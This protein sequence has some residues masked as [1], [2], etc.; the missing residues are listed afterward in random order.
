M[1]IKVKVKAGMNR[2]IFEEK[3]PDSFYVSVRE[4]AHQNLANDR[5]K[6]LIERHFGVVEGKVRLV[7]GQRS[8]SKIFTVDIDLV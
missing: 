1:Y 6:T 7:L 2:E 5:V 4:P 3:A 8:P